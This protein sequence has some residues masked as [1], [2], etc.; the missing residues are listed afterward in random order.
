MEFK[1]KLQGTD[2][3]FILPRPS[4]I[5][6]PYCRKAYKLLLTFL[7]KF[8]LMDDFFKAFYHSRYIHGIKLLDF[9][10]ST[11]VVLSGYFNRCTCW[12]DAWSRGTVLNTRDEWEKAHNIFQY[13]LYFYF[14]DKNYYA[15]YISSFIDELKHMKHNPTL[16]FKIL[17]ESKS[18]EDLLINLKKK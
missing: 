5:T 15:K 16:F 6:K 14:N 12:S 10:D 1:I 13:I 7:D 4:Q 8:G 3:P 2:N 11:D 9:I 17:K 18:F